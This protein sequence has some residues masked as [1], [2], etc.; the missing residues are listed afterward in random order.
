[1][2]NSLSELCIGEIS[3]ILYRQYQAYVNKQM[4]PY[5]INFS[6]CA[7]LLKIPNGQTVTQTYIAEKLFCDNA[8]V[9]RNFQTLEKKGFVLRQKSPNDKRAALVSLTD[10]GV[11]AKQAGIK[12]RQKW[13][14]LILA[15]FTPQDEKKLVQALTAMAK[16]ALLQVKHL[17]LEE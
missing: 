7:Y 11:A 10:K 13:K 2:Q 8:I 9:T 5:K 12:A 1:M 6:E 17:S 15:G 3:S 14:K 4:K 16:N